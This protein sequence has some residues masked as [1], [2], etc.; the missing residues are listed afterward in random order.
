MVEISILQVASFLN[1]LA[2]SINIFLNIDCVSGDQKQL[3]I[4]FGAGFW[5]AAYIIIS[6]NL[7]TFGY[8]SFFRLE[9]AEKSFRMIL[10]MIAFN[11]FSSGLHI[12]SLFGEPNQFWKIAF[13]F[14]NIGF[15]LSASLLSF[16]GL[17]NPLKDFNNSYK[18][19]EVN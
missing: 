4:E 14:L 19:E 15:S 10:K 16:Y 2:G 11:F 13:V 8:A 1:L 17:K 3:L 18:K 9:G 7:S 12:W 5:I 6:S